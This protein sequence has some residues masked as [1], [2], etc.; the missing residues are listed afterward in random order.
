MEENKYENQ[1]GRESIWKTTNIEENKYEKAEI[2]TRMNKE[3][4]C[5]GAESIWSIATEQC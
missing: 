4:Y 3:E 2:L 5:N 1:Y